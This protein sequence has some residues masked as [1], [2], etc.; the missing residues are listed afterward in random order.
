MKYSLIFL[1]YLFFC[2]HCFSQYTRSNKKDSSKILNAENLLYDLK[3]D[4]KSK[5]TRK[6]PFNK[7]IFFDVRY[8]TSFIAIN[9]QTNRN[10]MI[11]PGN[12]NKKFS[13][14]D[15]LASGLTNYLNAFYADNFPGNNADLLCYVKKFSFTLKDTLAEDRHADKSINSITVELECFYK[16]GTRLYPALR[17]DTSYVVTI[18]RMKKTFSEL[19]KDMI[20]PFVERISNIDS[21]QSVKKNSYTEEQINERYQSRFNIPVLT[22]DQYK[23]GVYRNFKEFRNN[24]PSLTN[25]KVKTKGQAT[26]LYDAGDNIINPLHIFGFSDGKMCWIQHGAYCYPLVRVG[27][28]FEFLYPVPVR[29]NYGHYD[30]KLLLAL[31]MESGNIY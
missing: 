11:G 27:N 17:F 10:L 19:V 15:G 14:T 1:L 9:W 28:A 25:F 20:D 5:M 6:L 31:N 4:S 22:T 29:T 21:G 18:S 16:T 26:F 2:N 23:R 24:A 13:L 3:S 7:I 8:D 12:Y 30:I